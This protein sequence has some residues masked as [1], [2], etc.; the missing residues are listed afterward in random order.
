MM[1]IININ[2]KLL[3]PKKCKSENGLKSS[4]FSY[5]SVYHSTITKHGSWLQI[6]H[7]NSKSYVYVAE[8]PTR[9]YLT[10]S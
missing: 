1:G 10:H 2:S 3:D 9:G 7:S 8:T 6:P 5:I 4:G